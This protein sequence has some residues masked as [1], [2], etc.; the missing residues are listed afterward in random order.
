MYEL[1]IFV[2]QLIN[3]KKCSCVLSPKYGRYTIIIQ[4]HNYNTCCVELFMYIYNEDKLEK[5]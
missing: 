5:F 1:L 2:A 4:L 3:T